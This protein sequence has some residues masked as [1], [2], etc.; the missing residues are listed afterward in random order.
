M[1]RALRSA[2]REVHARVEARLAIHATRSRETYR[3]LLAAHLGF[4]EPVETRMCTDLL[5]A[6]GLDVEARRK[7][8]ALVDDLRARGLDHAGIAALPRCSAAPPLDRVSALGVAYVLEGSTLGGRVL[9]R[10]FAQTLGIGPATGG[11]YFEGYG[12]RTGERWRA[13]VDV[14][15]RCEGAQAP[16]VVDAAVATF[17]TF[18]AW[19]EAR[20]LL[21]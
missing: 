8:P 3:A 10:H 18:E 13:F 14:L 2:T 15:A 7:V 17:S 12:E 16:T 5:R 4:L 1:L 19:L 11:R 6:Y 20:G 9:A 21:Q